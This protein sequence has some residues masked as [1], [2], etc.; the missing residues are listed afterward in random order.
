MKRLTLL[1]VCLLLASSTASAQSGET[2]LVTLDAGSPLAGADRLAPQT[3]RFLLYTH[4]GDA[5]QTRSLLTRTIEVAQRDGQEV[6]RV[7]QRY[8]LPEGVSLDTSVVVRATLAP[9]TYAATLPQSTQRFTFSEA[10]VSGVISSSEQERQSVDVALDT[11]VYSAVVLDE[12]IKALPLASGAAFRFQ[13]YNPGRDVMTFTVRVTGTERLSLVGGASVDAWVLTV[14]GGPV[15]STLWVTQATQ[16]LI[17][18]RTPLPT[19]DVFW[20][21]RLYPM[22]TA[23][24]E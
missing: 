1:V 2:G 6:L 4:T 7:I 13:A 19:G 22:P 17:R 14:E 8:D 20:K 5:R 9:V 11:P 10:A 18:S 16:E 23:D 15:P 24:A 3:E 21:A 12:L